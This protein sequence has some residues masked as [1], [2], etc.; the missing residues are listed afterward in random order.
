MINKINGRLSFLVLFFALL[1]VTGILV[2]KSRVEKEAN[3]L[4]LIREKE[5]NEL[6]DKLFILQGR[7]LELF[8]YDYT[9]WDEMVNFVYKPDLKWAAIN[10]DLVLA[11]YNMHVFIIK[12]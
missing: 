5:K 2:D 11:S 1:F 10:I 12:V 4:F 6:F 3:E 7:S 9:Y 8:T